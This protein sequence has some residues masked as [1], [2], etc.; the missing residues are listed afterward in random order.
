MLYKLSGKVLVNK[1]K[2]ILSD[3]ISPNQSAFILERFITD[4]ILMAFEALH[5]NVQI[6]LYLQ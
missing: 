2:K 3:I 6:Y 1:M 5:T 4:N